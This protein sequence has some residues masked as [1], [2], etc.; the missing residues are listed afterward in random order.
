MKILKSG[1]KAFSNYG[2]LKKGINQ[3]IKRVINYDLSL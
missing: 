3:G 1:W 2:R